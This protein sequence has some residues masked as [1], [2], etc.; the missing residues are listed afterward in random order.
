MRH[1]LLFIVFL[2]G[3][4]CYSQ[5]SVTPPKEYYANISSGDSLAEEGQYKKATL[6]YLQAFESFG[7]RGIADDR[8]K[9]AKAFALAGQTDSAF[10]YLER[11]CKQQ[12]IN[13]LKLSGDAALA[14]IRQKATQKWEDVLTCI[15][16]NKDSLAPNQNLV[17]TNYLDTIYQTDQGIR[18]KLMQAA[19]AYGWDSKEAKTYLPQMRFI[20]SVNQIKTE[21]FIDTHGWRGQD[22]LGYQGNATLFLVIQHSDSAI[23]EKYIP[24]LREAVKQKKARPEDLALMEDRLS[25]SK[26]GYQIYGSQIAQDPT[27]KKFFILQIKDEANV[28]KKRAE[29]GLQSLEEYVKLWGIE[30]KPKTN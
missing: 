11:L 18:K 7:W 24:L 10:T 12:Y 3:H 20:D 6:H 14:I 27:T 26:D 5:Q 9:A 19:N 21:R 13:Y 1:F 30:Y 25:I 29:V 23:Q 17:W 8:F 22:E 2:S 16:H 4:I 15:K 28:N